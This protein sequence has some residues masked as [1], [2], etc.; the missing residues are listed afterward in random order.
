M[1]R[2]ALCIMSSLNFI[3]EAAYC[4]CASGNCVAVVPAPPVPT[5]K[6]YV[7]PGACDQA[8]GSITAESAAAESQH[9]RRRFFARNR[10]RTFHRE[11]SVT[12][13]RS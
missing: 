5:A 2:I 4:E 1:F 11:T 12:I 6:A 8:A 9:V 10:A 3:P 7:A 13:T